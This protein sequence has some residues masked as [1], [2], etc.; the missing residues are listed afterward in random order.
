MRVIS[1]S[2]WKS[3]HSD[4]ENRDPNAFQAD[5]T[6]QRSSLVPEA[7]CSKNIRVLLP[8]VLRR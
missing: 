1:L 8:P 4:K 7:V 3:C 5:A 2:L 6:L